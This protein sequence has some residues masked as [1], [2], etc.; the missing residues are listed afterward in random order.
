MAD[1]GT[2]PL[3]AQLRALH[4]ARDAAGVAAILEPFA[5]ADIVS[6]PHN[7]FYLADAL[8]RLGRR[9]DALE[10]LHDADLSFNRRGNDLLH[11]RRRN[12][13]GMIYFDTGRIPEAERAWRSLLEDASEVA[14]EENIARANQNL[15]AIYTLQVRTE[16]AIASYERAMAAYRLMGHRRGLAQ[17]HHN[18]GLTYRELQFGPKADNHFLQA[19][20]YAIADHSEDE[21]ARA[22]QERA[23][24]IYT[25]RRDAP[26]A[27]VTARRALERFSALRESAGVGEALRVLGLIEL[28]E[29]E[30]NASRLHLRDA[31][32]HAQATANP[33]LEAESLEAVSVL[34]ERAGDTE[35]AH[36]MRARAQ[37]LFAEL[38]AVEW[39]RRERERVRQ[40]S[41]RKG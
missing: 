28:G 5:R 15:G 11:R 10:L 18:L 35:R 25:D 4:D 27:R 34:D 39:G 12:L 1:T 37:T 26:L 17:C 40:I 31:L 20:R 6:N 14:D 19:I 41:A 32:A 33:L 30:N 2:D 36:V 22:E 9:E 38:G 16:E 3:A 13:E 29:G 21:I 23:L 7:A 24:L 8:R